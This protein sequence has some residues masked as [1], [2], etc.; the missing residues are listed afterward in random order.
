MGLFHQTLKNAEAELNKT[1]PDFEKASKILVNHFMKHGSEM[2][3]GIL[4]RLESNCGNYLIN[5]ED[6][7]TAT[8]KKDKPKGLEH[9]KMC[10]AILKL[11]KKDIKKLIDT[12]RISLE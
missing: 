12:E 6:A 4:H 3:N 10:I 2:S 1:N 5:L 11:I 7:F 8:K 9:T